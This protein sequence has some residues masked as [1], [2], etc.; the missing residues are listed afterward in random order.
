MHFLPSLISLSAFLFLSFVF[1][2]HALFC[3]L[4][5]CQFVC[6]SLFSP[7]SLLTDGSLAFPYSAFLS[8]ILLFTLSQEAP[9]TSSPLTTPVS[10]WHSVILFFSSQYVLLP[11]TWT[12]NCVS[13]CVP[14]VYVRGIEQ[15]HI[16][17]E[18]GKRVPLCTKADFQLLYLTQT[19]WVRLWLKSHDLTG[20]IHAVILN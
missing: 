20:I 4:S 12:G 9:A 15:P 19:T 3:F 6:G 2:H 17:K 10:C 8:K 14:G 16:K 7:L 1:S 13:V 18:K 5:N 11:L